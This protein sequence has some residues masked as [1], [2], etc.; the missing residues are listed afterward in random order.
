MPLPRN[1]PIFAQALDPRDVL[2]FKV[3]LSQAAED[4]A[5]APM[6]LLG[7]GVDKLVVAVTS[8]AAAVGFKIVSG[9]V[10]GVTYPAPFLDS[11][12]V[13]NYWATVD[14]ARRGDAVFNNDGVT[15]GVE[16]TITTNNSPAREKQ[17]TVGHKV[18]QQ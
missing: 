5:V 3:A 2:D 6:L 16:I 13:V 7:E 14:D 10:G 1:A 15:V 11:S 12:N 18:A 9:N 17:R 8:E 4:A